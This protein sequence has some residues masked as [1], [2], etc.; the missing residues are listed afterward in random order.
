MSDKKIPYLNRT[1]DDYRESFLE[2]TKKYYPQ[3]AN[4]FNDAS[5]GSWFVDL[6]S[7][8]SD[9]L[10]YH[11]DKVFNETNVNSAQEKSSLFA[12]ARNNGFKIPGPKGAMAEVVFTCKVPIGQTNDVNVGNVTGSSNFPKIK[13]G[14]KLASGSQ[15]FELVDDV[16]FNEQFDNNG[17]SNRTIKAIED[18]NGSMTGWYSVSKTGVVVAGETKIYKQYIV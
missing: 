12:L 1:F 18:N 13:R 15:V 2:L 8:A 4:D 14:T 7:A 3:I 17:V 9:N 5:I 16:D 11:I 6:I 10:S